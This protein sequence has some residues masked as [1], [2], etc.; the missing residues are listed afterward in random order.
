MCVIFDKIIKKMSEIT[1][2]FNTFI[3]NGL[4]T[5]KMTYPKER[6]LKNS[7]LFSKKHCPFQLIN[8]E[9]KSNFKEISQHPLRKKHKTCIK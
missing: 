2:I 8:S 7:A 9:I 6:K 4:E 1:L 5:H 3:Y